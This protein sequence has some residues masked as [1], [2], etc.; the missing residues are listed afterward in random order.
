MSRNKF[1]RENPNESFICVSCGNAVAPLESGGNQRN[2]CPH[3]LTSCHVDILT[4]DRRASCRGIMEPIG[5]WVQKNKEWSVIHKCQ[6]CGTVRINRIAA[7]DNELLLFAKAVEPIMNLPFP[8]AD[9][10]HNLYRI[11]LEKGYQK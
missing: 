11:S 8:P 9:A 1:I 3:C 10:L 6:Q 2:H 7:D 5:V 4:G